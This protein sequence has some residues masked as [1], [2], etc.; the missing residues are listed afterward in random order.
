M[1]TNVSESNAINL[2][3]DSL[4]LRPKAYPAPLPP[5]EGELRLACE[6]L[7]HAANHKLNA[8]WTSSAIKKAAFREPVKE[9]QG[10]P[11]H[12]APPQGGDGAGCYTFRLGSPAA[13]VELD[14]YAEGRDAA[15]ELL[16]ASIL[17]EQEDSFFGLD[18][19]EEEIEEAKVTF[20]P[21]RVTR[22]DIV[23]VE[24]DEEGGD[25]DEDDDPGPGPGLADNEDDVEEGLEEEDDEEDEEGEDEA[26]SDPRSWGMFQRGGAR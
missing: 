1:T 11:E 2:L 21:E 25:E 12:E 14:V 6:I 9:D 23:A 18:F 7:A 17:E 4:F 22:A 26:S 10:P 8:G 19:D 15:V 13:V 3:L 24:L 16:R 5:S 20:D